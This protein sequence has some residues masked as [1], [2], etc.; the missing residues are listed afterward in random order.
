MFTGFGVFNV[1]CMHRLTHSASKPTVTSTIPRRQQLLTFSLLLAFLP[2][3]AYSA[4]IEGMIIIIINNNNN[5]NNND[6]NNN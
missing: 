4:Y 6:N 1:P 5:N 2:G 3:L